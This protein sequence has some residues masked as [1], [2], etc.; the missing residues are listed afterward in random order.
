MAVHARSGWRDP[1]SAERLAAQP[2]AGGAR[3]AAAAC[4]AAY[5]FAAAPRR[6][7]YAEVDPEVAKECPVEPPILGY[8]GACTDHLIGDLVDAP[9]L[10]VAIVADP[11]LV[12]ADNEPAMCRVLLEVRSNL[13]RAPPGMVTASGLRFDNHVL[14]V[15]GRRRTSQN[16]ALAQG[17]QRTARATAGRPSA[18]DPHQ[19]AWSPRTGHP[20]DGAR[21]RGPARAAVTRTA[22]SRPEREAAVYPLAVQPAEIERRARERP[23]RPSPLEPAYRE[24]SE[25]VVR[26]QQADVLDNLLAE[27]ERIRFATVSCRCVCRTTASSLS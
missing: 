7:G 8:A 23:L 1:R 2:R 3:R 22:P 18:A 16:P 15:A 26:L 5:M 11:N 27:R 12:V 19:A 21:R 14:D 17:G 6:S 20:A 4:R 24:P 25:R 13:K 10:N 9:N